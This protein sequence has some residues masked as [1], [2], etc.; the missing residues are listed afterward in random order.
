MYGI[1]DT[2]QNENTQMNPRSPYG[3]AKLFAHKMACVYCELYGMF[4]SCGVLFNHESER[5][6][7]EFV[8]VEK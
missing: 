5:R 1:T 2:P 3:V 6:G 4:I 8:K 7:I